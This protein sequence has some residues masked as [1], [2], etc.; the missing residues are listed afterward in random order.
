MDEKITTTILRTNELHNN[1]VIQCK[2]QLTAALYVNEKLRLY[3][4]IN[5]IVQ[6]SEGL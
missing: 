5:I 1:N 4:L 2:A 6:I 3:V